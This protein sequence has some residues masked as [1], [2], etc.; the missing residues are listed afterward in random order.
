MSS[1]FWT[2]VEATLNPKKAGNILIYP[3]PSY[4]K[5]SQD[6][7]PLQPEEAVIFWREKFGSPPRTPHLL[8]HPSWLLAD[9]MAGGFGLR[10]ANEA[11]IWC[12]PIG[13]F[14]LTTEPNNR[15][16]C[17]YVEGLCVSPEARG[18]GHTRKL[19]D[20]LGTIVRDKYGPE[21]RFLF[22]KEGARVPTKTLASD[23]Y[24][25]KRFH[26]HQR[27]A[28]IKRPI[29]LAKAKQ[30]FNTLIKS[31]KEPWLINEPDP[32]TLQRTQIYTD[33]TESCLLAI[34][35]THQ[36]HPL[37]GRRLGLITGWIVDSTMCQDTQAAL[38]QY[39]LVRQPYTW[40]W[41]PSSYIIDHTEW[42]YD[43]LISWQPFQWSVVPSVPMERLF[44]I[45]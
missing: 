19:L 42:L 15:I 37:D 5:P 13:N 44:I 36:H 33:P 11:T 43:G 4:T 24:L 1:S 9:T 8:V 29:S 39:L 40:I 21:V 3:L 6:I 32:D 35:E 7:R 28:P 18:R 30:I 41:S 45:L 2:R 20:A 25:Y 14:Y 22:L 23:I 27:P 26:D 17:L 16:T 10:I 38:Q 31:G 34:T 12:R